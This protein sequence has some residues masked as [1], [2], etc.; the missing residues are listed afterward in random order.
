M[1]ARAAIATEPNVIIFDDVMVRE[2]QGDEVA[3]RVTSV[4]LCGTDLGALKGSVGLFPTVLGHEGAGVIE[5][6]GPDVKNF[7]VGERVCMTYTACGK[8]KYCRMGNTN[9]CD[10]FGA[11]FFSPGRLRYKDKPLPNWFGQNSFSSYTLTTEANLARVP[12]GMDP[13]LAGPYGC[14]IMTGAGS[15]FD[16]N[17]G[18]DDS[19]AV[20]GLGTLGMSAIMAAKICGCKN[21]VAVGGTK[22]KQ[23]LA[24][25]LGATHIIDRRETPD[26]AAEMN[27]IIPGGA[28]CIV[29]TTGKAAMCDQAFNS[30]A[31]M[32]TMHMSAVYSEPVTLNFKMRNTTI[33]NCSMGNWEAVPN[34]EKLMKYTVEGKFPV[35]RIVRYY[36]FEDIKKAID[37]LAN[38]RVIK[39]V[40]KMD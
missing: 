36:P 19:A 34:I 31:K 13:D 16:M 1:K 38:Q 8:C 21:I 27:R 22:W 7:K 30:L 25:E 10:S 35:D 12:D 28:D 17:P 33:K 20:F 9:A 26:I 40:L 18:P 5:A 3:V 29:E 4:G 37:D 14:G 2:P 6:V 15:M 39:A 23:D 32:G 11:N 24:I